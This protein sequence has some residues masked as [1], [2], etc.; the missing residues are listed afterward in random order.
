VR[1]IAASARRREPLPRIAARVFATLAAAIVESCR[2]TKRATNLRTVALSGTCFE[3]RALLER[4]LALLTDA[5][6]E[7][8]IPRRVPPGESGVALGQAAIAAYCLR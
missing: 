1:A 5:G 4:T 2:R 3:S 8:L 7:V 6:F